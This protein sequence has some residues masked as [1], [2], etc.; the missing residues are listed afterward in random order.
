MPSSP[1][2][3]RAARAIAEQGGAAEGVACDVAV[4]AEVSALVEG[5][6]ARHDRLDI[7]VNN[8]GAIEPIATLA[9]GDPGD[10]ATS[11]AVNLTGAYHGA[12]AALPYFLAQGRGVIVNVSSGAAHRAL[13][14]WS[15]YCAGKAGLTMLTRSLHLEA[16]RAGVRVHGFQPGV[17][18]TDMQAR[19]RHSGINRVARLRR[20]DLAPAVEPARAIAWL[21]DEAAAPLA[22]RELGLG[23]VGQ[24]W[25]RALVFG[26]GALRPRAVRPPA[27][28]GH[29]PT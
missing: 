18:D 29:L 27:G 7:I 20:R 26:V 13:E 5:V 3:E 23:L 1:A 25:F 15:A 10:W 6:L 12:R 11:V 4:W 19:I 2:L 24:A 17:V 9:E 28:S 22:G 21:C 14:G 16:R 8:A